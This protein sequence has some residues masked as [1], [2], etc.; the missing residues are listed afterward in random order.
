MSSEENNLFLDRMIDSIKIHLLELSKENTSLTTENI[1]GKYI[2]LTNE[3]FTR[4]VRIRIKE[5]LNRERR[6]FLKSSI[7]NNNKSNS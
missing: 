2:E 5:D 3:A 1:L 4:F 7:I 6:D